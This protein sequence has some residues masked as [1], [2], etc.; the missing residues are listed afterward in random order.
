MAAAVVAT[1]VLD[2]LLIPPFETV[3]QLLPR[4]CL[5][6]ERARPGA[7]SGGSAAP[8]ELFWGT[9][10]THRARRARTLDDAPAEDES[11]ALEV[12]RWYHNVGPESQYRL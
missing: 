10:K 11:T 9:G 3:V 1:A 2:L 4:H 12:G 5:S 7:F 6:D 8:I